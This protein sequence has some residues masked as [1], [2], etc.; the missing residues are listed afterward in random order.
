MVVQMYHYGYLTDEDKRK[1]I[2]MLK[3]LDVILSQTIK[4]DVTSEQV[5][6]IEY[7]LT[8]LI[9][10]VEH[11]THYIDYKP[12]AAKKEY[13]KLSE[14]LKSEEQT[15]VV[16]K[17]K[18]EYKNGRLRYDGK[19]IQGVKIKKDLVGYSVEISGEHYAE[20]KTIR[21]IHSRQ[22]MLPAVSKVVFLGTDPY[23]YILESGRMGLKSQ[24]EIRKIVGARKADSS[25]SVK[26]IVSAH[27]VWI[28][29]K[30]GD[31]AKFAIESKNLSV[32][33]PKRQKGYRVNIHGKVQYWAA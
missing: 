17:A 19:E 12:G 3:K 4:G 18:L 9:A 23:C 8:L 30:R 25:I 6:S 1:V 13:L 24:D 29:V 32:Q 21:S 20:E 31:P 11:E 22:T 15:L 5:N 10:F 26:V 2:A 28:R 7:F 16:N 33:A 27:S 14:L